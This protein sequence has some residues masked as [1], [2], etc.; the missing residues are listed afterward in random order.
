[1]WAFGANNRKAKLDEER[2]VQEQLIKEQ[3]KTLELE[4]ELRE[5]EK[6]KITQK[7]F[8]QVARRK[9]RQE[10]ENEKNQ[11]SSSEQDDQQKDKKSLSHIEMARQGY[12][13]LVDAIIRPPRAKY[14][15]SVHGE[16]ST[17]FSKQNDLLLYF[18]YCVMLC[19]LRYRM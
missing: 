18:S 11:S 15:A 9:I 14:K 2:Q 7:G 16:T 6:E 10:G 5:L 19:C 4:K 13:Q 12:Q 3:L 1:M 17:V 8:V